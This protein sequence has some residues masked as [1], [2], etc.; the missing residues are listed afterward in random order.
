VRAA[1]L[2][3]SLIPRA[4]SDVS[5]RSVETDA[6]TKGGMSA[7]ELRRKLRGFGGETSV[8]VKVAS[9]AASR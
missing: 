9:A 7:V 6:A 1:D 4:E 2:T 5:D 3:M 8:S